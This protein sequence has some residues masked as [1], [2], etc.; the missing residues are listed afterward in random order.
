MKSKNKHTTSS[1]NAKNARRHFKEINY[2]SLL[3]HLPDIVYKIDPGGCFVY[4]NSAIHSLGYLPEEL[5]GK[6]FSCITHPD[7]I[8]RIS[9]NEVLS[10]LR[11]NSL[12]LQCQPKLFDERRTG[13]RMTKN[14][15]LRLVKKG[16]AEGLAAS[17]YAFGDIRYISHFDRI[18]DG[19]DMIFSGTIGVIRDITERKRMEEELHRLSGKILTA[20]DEER[21][22]MAIKLFNAVNALGFTSPAAVSDKHVRNNPDNIPLTAREKEVLILIAKGYT[23]RKIADSLFISIKTA[24]THRARVMKKLSVHKAVDL[25]RYAIEKNLV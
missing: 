14:L 15:E 4:I 2:K 6:H 16:V 24:E 11:K 8:A 13:K 3:D 17:V 21:K 19:T 10:Y 12:K 25:V 7:D 18:P 22:K 20:R 23:N 1:C 9:R 5:I